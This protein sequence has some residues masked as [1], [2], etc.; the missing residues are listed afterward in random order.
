M[1]QPEY[2]FT[3]RE[4]MIN[5]AHDYMG[6]DER[7]KMQLKNGMSEEMCED[8]WLMQQFMNENDS[9]IGDGKVIPKFPECLE[10]VAQLCLKHYSLPADRL[11]NSYQRIFNMEFYNPEARKRILEELAELEN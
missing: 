3:P 1:N 5:L 11:K 8:F 4:V 10:E 7:W 2:F 9:F 6:I